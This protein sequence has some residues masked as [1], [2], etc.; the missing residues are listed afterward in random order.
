MEEITSV[1]TVLFECEDRDDST[2]GPAFGNI[3]LPK[4]SGKEQRIFNFNRILLSHCEV[5]GSEL[6][7]RKK[8]LL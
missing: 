1:I 4:L 3:K 5:F 6:D 7:A 2:L 8:I